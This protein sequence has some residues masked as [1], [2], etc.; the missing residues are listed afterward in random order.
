MRVPGHSATESSDRD[1]DSSRSSASSSGRRK[2]E[3]GSRRRRKR[4]WR[5]REG[6]GWCPVAMASSLPLETTATSCARLDGGSSGV[7]GGVA[8]PKPLAFSID[9]IMSIKPS[10]PR[11]GSGSG[12][13][14]GAQGP[15]ALPAQPPFTYDLHQAAALMNYA[16]LWRAG[17]RGAAL[18][19]SAAA[20]RAAFCGVCGGGSG[21]DAAPRNRVIKPQ[22]IHRAV[23]AAAAAAPLYYFG[24]LD[25]ACH[26]S[27]LLNGRLFSSSAAAAAAAV[28]PHGRAHSHAAPGA[29]HTLLLLE[30]AKLD[31]LPTPQHPH[32]ERLPGQL[33]HVVKENHSAATAAADRSG[34]VKAHANGK[35]NS[36]AA[37]GKPKSFTC[38]VCG[39]VFNAHYNLTRHM[40]V[41][42]GARPFV[43]K[44]CGKGFRQASTLCRHKIIHTQEKPHKCNQCGKA[45]NRSSTL[46]THVRIH[47]G[48]KPFVCE[49]CGKGF[50]QKGNYKNHKLTHSG[51]KQFKCS[52][53]SKAF[54]QIYNLTFH[55]HTHNDKKPFTC[56]TCGKGFC[57]NFDLKK[58]VRKLHESGACAA[59]VAHE[60]SGAART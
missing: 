23:A 15:R 28:G 18:C 57:R 31:R 22:V 16:E 52:I 12:G 8:S 10:G 41:H 47:A 39:K 6:P 20:C 36:C 42:T 55:M 13:C 2:E 27:E 32:K 49:F 26:P 46:N 45:F 21:A 59:P 35:A 51:E 29:Q 33:D 34:A 9:R 14:G 37:D 40:P 54:H 60:P 5:R 53:C 19:A 43:C 24:C 38:E 11:G 48:Y 1:S 30:G 25:S 4:R 7:G 44:V 50:H 3:K 17:F 58:H 56:A